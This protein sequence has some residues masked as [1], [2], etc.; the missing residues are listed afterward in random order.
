MTD[1]SP[2]LESDQKYIDALARER[3]V[4]VLMLK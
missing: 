2:D 1:T 4:F 3:P